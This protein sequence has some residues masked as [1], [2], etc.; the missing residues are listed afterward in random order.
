M[1]RLWRP[2][3]WIVLYGGWQDNE[4]EAYEAG[5]DAMIVAFLTML[6]PILASIPTVTELQLDGDDEVRDRAHS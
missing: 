2:K 6:E 3:D 5:A 4:I 1:E